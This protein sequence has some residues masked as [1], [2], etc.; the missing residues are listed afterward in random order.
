MG[1]V[2]GLKMLWFLYYLFYPITSFSKKP[3]FVHKPYFPFTF[4]M[5]SPIKAPIKKYWIGT[6][7]MNTK[8]C[9]PY[10]NKSAIINDGSTNRIRFQ[11]KGVSEQLADIIT[12]KIPNK[13]K[14]KPNLFQYF[15]PCHQVLSEVFIF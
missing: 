15:N 8:S 7:I 1:W 9:I 2:C 4:P 12:T 11:Q 14:I 10:E 6:R 13:A 3:G 5:I